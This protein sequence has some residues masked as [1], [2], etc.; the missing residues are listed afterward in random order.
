VHDDG[1]NSNRVLGRLT[2]IEVHARAGQARLPYPKQPQADDNR[3]YDESRLGKPS[4]VA[5]KNDAS[6]DLSRERASGGSAIAR[7][8][9]RNYHPRGHDAKHPI[10]RAWRNGA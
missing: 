3:W 1:V 10:T 9:A 6:Y 8:A 2:Q 5:A 4:R 7:F